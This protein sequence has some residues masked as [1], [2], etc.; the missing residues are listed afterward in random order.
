MKKFFLIS[1]FIIGILLV[2]IGVFGLVFNYYKLGDLIHFVHINLNVSVND[3]VDY[4]DILIF[5][6]TII[7]TLF[8]IFIVLGVFIIIISIISFLKY[9]GIFYIDK[10]KYTIED[11]KLNK[12]L[13][14][15]EKIN[16]KINKLKEKLENIE[17]GE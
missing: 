11:F 14:N 13:K 5:Y 10:I 16:K 6:E 8:Y 7:K 15:Q 3:M 17:K 2:G 9:N 12:D 4:L 1:I